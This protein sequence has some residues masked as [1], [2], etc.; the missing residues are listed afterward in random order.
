MVGWHHGL[1]GH[2]FAQTQGDS[3]AQGS[4]ACCS[5]RGLTVGHDLA[6]EQ[7]QQVLVLYY[8]EHSLPMKNIWATLCGFISG[9][10]VWLH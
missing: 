8:S 6:T 10:S 3:E 5:S 2:K 4:L 7:P 9:L 1:N